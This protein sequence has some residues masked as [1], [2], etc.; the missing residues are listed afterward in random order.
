VIQVRVHQT[1]A[2]SCFNTIFRFTILIGEIDTVQ[3]VWI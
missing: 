3:F 1:H 2:L